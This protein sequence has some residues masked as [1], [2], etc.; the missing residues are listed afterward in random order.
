MKFPRRVRLFTGQLDV[1][2]IASLFFLLLT[3]LLL[4]T[5]LVPPPGVRI[6]LPRVALPNLPATSNPWLAVAVDQVGR[7][8]F[9]N[10]VVTPGELRG[11]LANRVRKAGEPVSLLIQADRAAAQEVVMQ[12][13]ALA[14]EAGVEE[15]VVA[16]RPPLVGPGSDS[17]RP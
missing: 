7:T 3:L 12:L 14:R 4:Q 1:A 11:N 9:E 16:T 6:D 15:V 17:T 13:Y 5:H 2:P 10:Q 8:Y